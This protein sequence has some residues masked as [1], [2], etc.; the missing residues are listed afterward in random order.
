MQTVVRSLRVLQTLST[1][2]DGLTLLELCREQDLPPS[3]MHR[4][5]GVLSREE[6][7]VRSAET[8]RFSLGP[9]AFALASGPRHIADAARDGAALLCEATGETTFIAE[10]IGHRAVCVSLFES[11]RPLRLFVRIGQDL[12]LHAAASS[13]AILAFL[14]ERRVES[15]LEG[16]LLE[17]FTNETPV[18]I[19]DV[20]ARLAEIRERG[21]DVCSEELDPNVWAVGAP[22]RN[23]NNDVVASVTVAGPLDRMSTTEEEASNRGGARRVRGHFHPTWVRRGRL[24]LGR[25]RG[26]SDARV[27][28]LLH[29]GG[30]TDDDLLALGQGH[31]L[32]KV[33]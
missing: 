27:V 10:L 17:R 11:R 26:M 24:G 15:M 4:L 28:A 2:P 6:F 5:V 19:A 25:G 12:P 23:A 3:T 16:S 7:V 1:W 13:R 14:D 9:Q 30:L 29:E 8:K 20:L 18:T 22:I 33:P 21:Y 32:A 31:D